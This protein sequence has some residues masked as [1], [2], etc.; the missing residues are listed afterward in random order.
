M[1]TMV[2]GYWTSYLPMAPSESS[3]PR[4]TDWQSG[5]TRKMRGQWE[6]QRAEPEESICGQM[7]TSSRS[8]LFLLKIPNGCCLFQSRGTANRHRLQPIDSRRAEARA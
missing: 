7:I 1:L 5:S 8:V 2:I 3:L 4:T 6:G